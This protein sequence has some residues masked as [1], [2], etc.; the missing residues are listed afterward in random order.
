MS[1]SGDY[2]FDHPAREVQERGRAALGDFGRATLDVLRGVEGSIRSSQLEAPSTPAARDKFN[3]KLVLQETFELVKLAKR[4][5]KWIEP[6]E[7]RAKWEEYG[8][9]GG[10]EHAVYQD[11]GFYIKANTRAFHGNWGQYLD[12]LLM[13]NAYFPDVPYEVAGVTRAGE[14]NKPS[15]VVRQKGVVADGGN[16]TDAEINAHMVG[17]GGVKDPIDEHKYHFEGGIT[18]RDVRD[19]NVIKFG[20]DLFV[21]DPVITQ[22][23]PQEMREWEA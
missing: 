2:E 19:E 23:N 12:R 13:H 21:F 17:L 20:D 8:K 15:I 1:L 18:I 10:I 7:F 3:Q 14:D 11:G 16:P 6:S 4:E 22:K 9:G 5:G